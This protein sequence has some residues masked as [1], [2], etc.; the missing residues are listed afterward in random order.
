MASLTRRSA[1]MRLRAEDRRSY[2]VLYWLT[3]SLFFVVACVA[4]LMPRR[5]DPSVSTK[6]ER[7]SVLADARSSASAAIGYAFMG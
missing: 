4:R 6:R 7:P 1:S 3:F 2:W 5:L